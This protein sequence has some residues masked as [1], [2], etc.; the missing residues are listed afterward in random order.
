MNTEIHK[1][2]VHKHTEFTG[3]LQA[4]RG[5]A[6][7]ICVKDNHNQTKNYGNSLLA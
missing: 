4:L 1:H 7:K 5:D 2:T 3:Q 6:Y